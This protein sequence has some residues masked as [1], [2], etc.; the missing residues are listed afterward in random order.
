MQVQTDAFWEKTLGKFVRA[1]KLSCEL[2]IVWES[3][4]LL[5]MVITSDYLISEYL[6]PE[7][8]CL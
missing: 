8:S 2:M 5:M 1:S 7:R 3:R 4:I 6:F